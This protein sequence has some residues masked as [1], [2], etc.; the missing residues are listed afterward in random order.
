MSRR[1]I[2]VIGRLESQLAL[3]HFGSFPILFV[4]ASCDFTVGMVPFGTAITP[5][6]MLSVHISIVCCAKVHLRAVITLVILFVEV[7]AMLTEGNHSLV[8]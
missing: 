7:M 4:G 3:G 6:P 2:L 1:S 8:S 5:N